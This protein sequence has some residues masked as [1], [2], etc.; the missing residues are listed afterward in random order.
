M[1]SIRTQIKKQVLA[2]FTYL[3]VKLKLVN[4]RIRALQR[5]TQTV[6]LLQRGDTVTQT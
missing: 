6:A 4:A 2:P 1:N 5:A 3:S